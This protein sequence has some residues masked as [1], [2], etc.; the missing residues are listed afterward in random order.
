[1]KYSMGTMQATKYLMIVWNTIL[2]QCLGYT[3]LVIGISYQVMCMRKLRVIYSKEM[4]L[5][6]KKIKLKGERVNEL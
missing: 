2:K 3:T 4:V 6:C 5:S 1:M